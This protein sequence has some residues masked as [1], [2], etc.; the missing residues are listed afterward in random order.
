MS[1]QIFNF[2]ENALALG[3]DL[4]ERLAKW[5]SLRLMMVRG[6]PEAFTRDE[7]AYLVT[8]LDKHSLMLP[9]VQSF[10]SRMAGDTS[11]L[12]RARG[13]IAIWLPNNV[14]L[15]GPLALILSSFSGAAIRVK[16]GSRS[17]DLCQAFVSYA[18]DHLPS[19]ELSHYL[20]SQVSIERFSRED[21][22]NRVMAAESSVRIAFGSDLATAAV[23]SLPHPV[24]ST[25]ISFA[26]HRSEA[27]VR[28]D[29]LDD[30][31][32][33]TLIKVFTIYGQAGCTSPRRV[34]IIDGT[35]DD[36]EALRAKMIELWP[37]QD[38]PMHIA[39]QNI[40]HHQLACASEWNAQ[41]APRNAAVLGIGSLKSGEMSGLMSLAIVASTAE[42]AAAAL[43]ANIQTVGHHFTDAGSPSWL[44]LVAR[45]P[46]KRWVPINQMHHFGAVWDGMNF[47]RQLFEEIAIRT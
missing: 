39:S 45:T 36:C 20:R 29:A 17:V 41:T 8:F 11:S 19:G 15:L 25:G 27:W 26:D 34:V 35:D 2:G 1:N 4:D 18:L 21:E 37:R 30:G 47:F 14:S 28:M 31:A 3:Y 44:S 12:F 38:M 46:I 43:P 16:V 40:L 9:F 13:P 22:R 42:Q 24:Q 6:V 5:D 32:V 33:T 7:W 10:G 23:H